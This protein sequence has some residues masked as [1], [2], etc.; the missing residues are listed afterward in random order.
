M[1]KCVINFAAG[2]WYGN[3]QKRLVESLK[4]TGFDGDVLTWS[5]PAV[6]GCLP[7]QQVPYGFKPYALK[8]AADKGYELVL[9]ADA[10]CWAIKNIQPMFDHIEEH[11]HLFFYN[12]MIG[13]FT[14]DRCLANFGV[15]REEADKMEMLMGICMG[16][17]MTN[18]KCQELLKDWV[19]AANDG[20]SFQGAWTNNNQEV[21]TSP[22]C[23]GHR[24]DQSVASILACRLKMDYVVAHHTYFQDDEPGNMIDEIV[25][26]AQGM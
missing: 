16:F 20:S 25:M 17:N 21:S 13:V 12:N 7:H 14:S 5:D 3:G 15:S 6:L 11:G 26:V 9:W 1:K 23:K 10:S 8:H 24:H 22:T 2:G 4:S 18:P 19:A